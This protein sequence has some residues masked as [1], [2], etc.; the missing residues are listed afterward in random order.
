M[1]QKYGGRYEI[2]KQIGGGGMAIVYLAK[3]IFLDRFVA[4]KV[5]RDEFVESEEFIRRFQKEAK[6]VASLN[7]P[8]IVSVYDFNSNETPIYLVMEY[9]EGKT[10]KEKIL[11]EGSLSENLA[12]NIAKQ[13]ANGLLVAHNAKIIHKDIKSQN[14][15]IDSENRIKIT[16]FGIAQ[17]L[18]NS[19][20]THNKGILGSAHYFSPEQAR[21]EIV[22]YKSDIYSL[23]I[24]LYEML[25]GELPF[26]GDNPVTV[27]LKHIQEKP[28]PPRAIN[29]NISVG[30]E[31]IVLKALSKHPE[32][33]FKDIKEFL[34]AL[35]SLKNSNINREVLYEK[36]ISVKPVEDTLS[37]PKNL[38]R[39]E[40]YQNDVK[41]TKAPE[42]KKKK[43]K[44]YPLFIL[45]ILITTLFAFA[46]VTAI[47]GLNAT[48]KEQ[49][50]VPDFLYMDFEEA[51]QLAEK[52]DITLVKEDSLY[53]DEYPEGV[54]LEQE[55]KS[56][57][58]LKKGDVVKIVVSKGS[59]FI[60]V[61][62]F[63]GMKQDE[64]EE[65][66]KRRGLKV[67]NPKFESS[68][69]VEKDLVI[70]QSPAPGVE[71]KAKDEIFL[72]ISLGNTKKEVTV[73][74]LIGLTV[75][76]AKSI[77]SEKGLYLGNTEISEDR[78]KSEGV[79]LAQNIPAKQK[80]KLGSSV[81]VTINK[82]SK[83]A[84]ENKEMQLTFLVPNSGWL[85]IEQND[86]S[87]SKNIYQTNANAGE[88]INET[89]HYKGSGSLSIYID[90]ELVKEVSLS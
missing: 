21:G 73:P 53:N 36:S 35:E 88:T 20:I 79:I 32:A 58:R 33:R 27:A 82:F 84:I 60:S 78:R 81:N 13:I 72:V 77:L 1:H 74:S 63:V 28:M 47:N 9:I 75:E 50:I 2:I 62:N 11:E 3:D 25:T 56:G 41:V 29:N 70:Y 40:L 6:A 17:I 71:V 51:E 8:N 80:V 59:E 67:G 19:T 38:I 61:P 87:G 12:V 54:V 55:P 18:N 64:A 48:K 30:L 15:L 69:E 83:P 90:G 24:V 22:T 26:T 37:L 46:T 57:E 89:I 23:G 52:K 31:A 76:N 10:L 65:R 16:D 7:H 34:N 5:L 44:K 14:I 85:T 39:K 42:P 43:S 86:A 4:V 45:L 68:E 66:I 49:N